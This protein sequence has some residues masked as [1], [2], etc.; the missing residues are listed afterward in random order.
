M[1]LGF[2]RLMSLWHFQTA[3]CP[4]TYL[5]NF[6][7]RTINQPEGQAVTIREY[8][9][10]VSLRLPLNFTSLTTH[11]GL[12]PF[13]IYLFFYCFSSSSTC[14]VVW[15]G[16]FSQFSC[17]FPIVYSYCPHVSLSCLF[18]QSLFKNSFKPHLE[19]V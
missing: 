3:Q 8:S 14:F 4:S 6:S 7:T 2:K 12:L 17:K 13:L 9:H 11:L 1:S 18:P 19:G 5:L 16:C 10:Q 15:K